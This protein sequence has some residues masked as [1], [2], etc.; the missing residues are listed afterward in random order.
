M[1]V[2]KIKV[3]NFRS[4]KDV[5]CN[6]KNNALVLVGAN[7]AGKSSFINAV[8][9]FWGDLEVNDDD[10]HK[11][12]NEIS[13]TIE[14]KVFKDSFKEEY[15][16]NNR[17]IG[18]LKIP[19]IAGEYNECK[20]DTEVSDMS[21]NDYKTY[22]ENAFENKI[23]L[24][25]TICNE[26]W[27]KS[28]HSRLNVE[29][30]ICIIEYKILRNDKKGKYR[31]SN[32][33]EIKDF[34]EY[35]NKIA[36]IDDDRNFS[37]EEEGK[38]RTLTSKILGNHIMGSKD[39]ECASCSFIDCSDCMDGLHK[40]PV[41]ELDMND[42]EKL[43]NIKARDLSSD[44]SDGISR[45][46][47]SN[48]SNDYKIL[49]NTS[50][51]VDKS[52]TITTK[53]Y[54][55]QLEKYVDLSKVGAGV[56][57][58]YILSLLQAYLELEDLSDNLFII[59]EPEIYLHPKLQKLMGSIL[60]E[61]AQENF[62]IITTHSPI[63]LNRFE[64][65]SIKKVKLNEQHETELFESTLS[66]VLQELGYST[67]DILF[68]EFVI[69]VEGKDDKRWLEKIILT[70]YKVDI[71]KFYIIDT[72]SCNNIEIYASLRF[73]S[74]TNLTDNFLIFRDSDTMDPTV[75][76]KDL[77]NK[78]KENLEKEIVDSIEDKILVFEYSSFDNYFLVPERLQSIGIVKN[79]EDFNSKISNYIDK[80]SEDI[81]RY[82]NERNNSERAD[83][84]YELLFDDR[85]IDDK[86]EDIKRY[87]R[88]HNLF[89]QFGGLKRKTE[90]FIGKSEAEDFREII[91]HLNKFDYLSKNI[92]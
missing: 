72:K 29:D 2:N 58:I 86:I 73:L 7:N 60:Y 14:F 31:N 53:I 8:R 38:T 56:R 57:S 23:I 43:V 49:L 35:L 22:R 39:T 67:S 12:E 59:E 61:I 66:E 47:Q 64:L 83:E 32:N 88:G 21:Y 65:S 15:L 87:V 18:L 92:R 91:C 45:I 16:W 44:I 77:M 6:I 11:E 52:F 71:N 34:V 40:K 4:I 48:F 13:I 79:L 75:I 28:I 80:Y 63:V 1:K 55:P 82:L 74:K 68:T 3:C 51:N 50:S 10:F 85:N 26:I 27:E 17:K 41:K 84:L 46:F 19:S 81:K 54:V 90:D 30:G 20:E 70:H 36:F 37:E 5:E 9:I 25:L 69:L 24:D 33:L 78:F 62:I 42:L 89:G 76:K